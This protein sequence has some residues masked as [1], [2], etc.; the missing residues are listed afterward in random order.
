MGWL[1][2]GADNPVTARPQAPLDD[3]HS[4]INYCVLAGYP[5]P[6]LEVEFTFQLILC[7]VPA[8]AT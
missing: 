2:T 8:F 1:C 5:S 4:V 7:F 6:G 3:S